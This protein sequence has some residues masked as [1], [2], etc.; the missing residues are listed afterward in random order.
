MP[1]TLILLRPLAAKI[2]LV[3]FEDRNKKKLFLASK[4]KLFFLVMLA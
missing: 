2:R 4:V 3:N 1:E